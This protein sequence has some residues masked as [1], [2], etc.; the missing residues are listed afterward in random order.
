MVVRTRVYKRDPLRALRH[1]FSPQLPSDTSLICT[2]LYFGYK[3]R[4]HSFV[5][6]LLWSFFLFLS[7]HYSCIKTHRCGCKSDIHVHAKP[8]CRTASNANLGFILSLTSNMIRAEW[9]E[10]IAPPKTGIHQ[11]FRDFVFWS[12]KNV[13]TPGSQSYSCLKSLRVRLKVIL[14]VFRWTMQL[15]NFC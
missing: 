15:D 7:Y 2:F 10:Q 8:R 11:Q 14:R 13:W 4:V 12:H 6:V 3:D 9:H 1:D 5:Y